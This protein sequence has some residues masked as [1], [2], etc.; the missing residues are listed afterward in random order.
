MLSFFRCDISGFDVN[1]F[2]FVADPNTISVDGSPFGNL[3]TQ[4]VMSLI[5]FAHVPGSN[6]SS[7]SSEIIGISSTEVDRYAIPTRVLSDV[8]NNSGKR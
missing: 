8:T 4:A 7:E 6:N 3:S 2:G 1:G 5:Q